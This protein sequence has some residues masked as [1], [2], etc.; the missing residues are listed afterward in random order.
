LHGL[1][2]YI[3]SVIPLC[4]VYDETGG[5][6]DALAGDVDTTAMRPALRVGEVDEVLAGEEVAPHVGHRPLH[7]GLVLRPADPRAGSATNPRALA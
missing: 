7:P 5:A 6:V 2:G 3:G 1:K 4:V